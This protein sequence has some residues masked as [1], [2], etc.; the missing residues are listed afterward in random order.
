M[1]APSQLWATLYYQGKEAEINSNKQLLVNIPSGA[2]PAL[3]AGDNNIGNIDIVTLPSTTTKIKYSTST[4]ITCTLASLASSATVGRCS[5]AID[6]TTN[7]YDDAIVTLSI[8]TGANAPANDKAIYVYVYGSEDGTNYEQEESN[9]PASDGAYTINAPTIFRLAAIIPIL[10]AAKIY[11]T[12]FS[13]AT[14]YNGIMPRKWGIIV[15]NFAGQALD[16]TETNHIKTY[17]GIN[18]TSS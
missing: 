18:Y 4:A 13:I 15:I 7:L 16:S 6:N 11:T 2:F 8:K 5:T 17:T 9:S 3:P 1:A 10:T 14:M 12:V